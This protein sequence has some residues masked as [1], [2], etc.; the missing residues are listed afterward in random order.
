ML[1]PRPNEA[2]SFLME[3]EASEFLLTLLLHSLALI[4][5]FQLGNSLTL[6][7]EI[8]GEIL[9]FSFNFL[10]DE[11]IE[12]NFKLSFEWGTRI[13]GFR[14]LNLEPLR[15]FDSEAS[16]T[17]INTSLKKCGPAFPVIYNNFLKLTVFF[18][19]RFSAI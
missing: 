15:R 11:S 19:S 2:V 14:E 12:Y 7:F 8:L 4:S 16:R 6:K 1:I 3:G 17:G 10:S 13:L 18:W 5:T 9:P